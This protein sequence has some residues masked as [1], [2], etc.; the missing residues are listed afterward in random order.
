MFNPNLGRKKHKNREKITTY[1]DE[2][3][4][5]TFGFYKDKVPTILNQVIFKE[6]LTH[7]DNYNKI[8]IV[9]KLDKI[10]L[11]KYY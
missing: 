11:I 8:H 5:I 9:L 4:R 6:L 2:K 1:E 3:G 7:K 10:I